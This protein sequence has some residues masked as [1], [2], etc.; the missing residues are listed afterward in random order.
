MRT[1]EFSAAENEACLYHE[2]HDINQLTKEQKQR[3]A[4]VSVEALH[5]PL[6]L[7]SLDQKV[8][9]QEELSLA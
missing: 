2:E 6:H 5:F 4:Y 3:K 9:D 1:Q 7:L 8:Y